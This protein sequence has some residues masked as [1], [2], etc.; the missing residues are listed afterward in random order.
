[1]TAPDITVEVAFTSGYS[2]AIADMVWTDVSAYVEGQEEISINRGRS[3]EFSEVDPGQMTL[4][5]DNRD[6]RFTPGYES[7]AYWP[8]VKKGRPIRLSVTYDGVTYPRFFGYVDEWPVTWPSAGE[9]DCRV[10]ITASS[11][12]ARASAQMRSVIEEEWLVPRPL[13][14]YTLG[15][16]SEAT[17]AVDSSGNRGPNLAQTGA[18]TDVTFAT[19]TG[20]GTD[21]MSSPTFSAGKYL[22]STS[23][24]ELDATNGI[25]IAASFN[26]STAAGTIVALSG[27]GLTAT[28]D[29]AG[30][31]RVN[32]TG[33]GEVVATSVANGATRLMVIKIAADLSATLEVDGAVTGT[34]STSATLAATSSNT[35]S[36]GQSFTGTIS[37]V[38]VWE[39]VLDSTD[40][41]HMWTAVNTGFAGETPGAAIERFARYWGIPAAEVIAG[42]GATASLIFIDTT[43]KTP[44]E[45]MRLVETTEYGNLYDARDGTLEF[46]GRDARINSASSFD[47]SAAAQ[48]VGA[49]L[50][51]KLD[52]QGMMNIVEARRMVDGA[53]VVYVTNQGSVDEY[54]PYATALELVTASDA[55]VADAA[56][57]RVSRYG[58]P[59]IRIPSVAVD[60]ANIDS[61][62]IASLM[63][64]DVGTKFTLT[65]LP[66]QAPWSSIDLF[67]EGMTETIGFSSHTLSLNTSTT[68]LYASWQL[69]TVDRSELGRTTVLGY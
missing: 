17:V 32:A 66:S 2:T 12:M 30:T 6:G 56:T 10:T 18:G 27:L 48:H 43:D 51:P 57:W 50:S 13:V 61:A 63:A 23:T 37:H 16:D 29:G 58:E 9:E 4:T 60:V 35:V 69:E 49:D 20:P 33:M 44:L 34:S 67:A 54:G 5:F 19:A 11:R 40:S 21:G 38:A 24:V 25:T 45:A 64:A 26:T 53:P 41:G 3:D 59:A 8:N 68:D 22:A 7:G 55:E 36:V 65:N 1:M 42:T 47:L 14:Y 52:D 31:L 46:H 28:I 39:S 15:E 62:L